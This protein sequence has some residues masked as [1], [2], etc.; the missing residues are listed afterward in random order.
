MKAEHKAL[1][2]AR[3]E[4]A[5]ADLYHNATL[6]HFPDLYGRTEQE[7][8]SW[9]EG[10]CEF[11]IEYLRDGGAYGR[12]YRTTLAAPCNA[13]KYKSQDARNYYIAKGMRDMRAERNDCGM[14]T[15][16]RVLE[17]AAGNTRLARVLKKHKAA[18]RNDSL[19]ER[20]GEFGKLYQYGR[21]GR[22]LAPDGLYDD[23]RGVTWDPAE[24][25]IAACVDL[26]RIVESFNRYVSAWCDSTPEQWRDYCVEQDAEKAYEKKQAAIRKAKETR[27]R[28]HWACRDVATA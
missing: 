18:K 4:S 1:V 10:A 15:G 21:G 24:H 7:A 12:N 3:A 14:L 9:L 25:S 19:W 6:P 16:W 23:R 11:E 5:L 22:T 26:I 2:R 17:L 28:Q 20:I 13:G 27:E 8:Q